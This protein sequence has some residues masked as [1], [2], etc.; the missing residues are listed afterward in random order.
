VVFSGA[1]IA[2]RGRGEAPPPP[3][4][5]VGGP[6]AATIEAAASYSTFPEWLEM[7]RRLAAHPLV[8]RVEI[9]AISTDSA[10]LRL[11]LRADP[12]Q[13]AEQLAGAGV[14]LVPAEGRQGTAW[15]LR[16]GGRF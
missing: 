13:A 15:L 6:A 7:R 12:A 5:G 14:M 11:S 4:G 8:A 1:A 3:G 10:R 16:L 9:L 2:A